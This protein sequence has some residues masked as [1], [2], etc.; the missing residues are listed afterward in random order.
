M[1]TRAL[2]LIVLVLLVAPTRL[3][4][5]FMRQDAKLVPI[6]RLVSNLERAIKANPKD[7]QLLI[8]LARLHAMAFALKTEEFPALVSPGGDRDLPFF[9]QGSDPLPPEVR[10][11]PTP[12]QAAIA[13]QH[14]KESIKNYEAAVALAPENPLAH[15]GLGWVLQQSGNADRAVD[16]YRRVIT[17]AWPIEEKSGGLMPGQTYLTDEALTYLIPLLDPVKNKAEIADLKKK[18]DHLLARPRAITPIAIPLE[19][20]VSAEQI[21][22]DAARVRFDADGSALDREWSWITTRAGW[23]VYD[24]TGRGEIRSALQLFGNVT[25]WLFWSNGYEALRSLDN[26]GDGTLAGTE[27]NHLAIW[28]DRN[29]NG[30]SEAGE[31]QALSHHGIVALSCA[32]ITLDDARFAAISTRGALFNNGRTRPTYDVILRH[33]VLKLTG[34]PF[35]QPTNRSFAS[36]QRSMNAQKSAHAIQTWVHDRLLWRSSEIKP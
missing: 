9:G 5:I 31:V 8:N 33:S 4:A 16:E 22:D 3:T 17:L 25:F 13:D 24:A 34:V 7:V 20:D 35:H 1:A 10:K 32:Y 15:L 27:L 6:S 28:Q 26:N 30:I 14:L 19:D 12:E 18:E 11:P 29:S 21:L 23:L 2:A 36:E